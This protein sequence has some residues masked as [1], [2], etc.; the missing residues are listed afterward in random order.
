MKKILILILFFQLTSFSFAELKNNVIS[1][2]AC[3]LKVIHK[4]IEITYRHSN[5]S[6]NTMPVLFEITEF[7][8]SCFI[9]DNVYLWWT[10]SYKKKIEQP[11]VSVVYGNNVKNFKAKITGEAGPKCWVETGTI[12]YRADITD[13]IVG[14]GLYSI[15]VETSQ[16]ETDGLTLLII[17]R[18]LNSK[19]EGHLYIRDGLITKGDGTFFT[20]TTQVLDGFNA[21]D[22]ADSAWGLVIISDIQGAD[23]SYTMIVNGEIHKY[24]PKFW[25]SEIIPINIK[26]NQKSSLFGVSAYGDCYS[27]AVMG[28]YFQTSSCTNCFY[29]KNTYSNFKDTLVCQDSDV[30]LRGFG[31]DKYE[32]I[33]DSGKVIG[34]GR[35]FNYKARRDTKIL[36]R[37]FY[38]SCGIGEDSLTIRV[39]KKPEI[40]IQS[41]PQEVACLMT[42]K[43]YK[44]KIRNFGFQTEKI[45]GMSLKARN[46]FKVKNIINFPYYLA[47]NSDIDIEIEFKPTIIG[48]IRDTLVMMIEN[49]CQTEYLIPLSGEGLIN[50]SFVT[51]PDTAAIIGTRDFQIPLKGRLIC[52][53]YD[54]VYINFSGLISFDNSAYEP[55]VSKSKNVV[56]SYVSNGDR[57]LKISGRIFNIIDSMTTLAVLNGNVLFGRQHTTPLI[58][59]EFKWEDESISVDKDNGSL[60]VDACVFEL[61]QI[62]WL[63]NVDFNIIQKPTTNEI[64]IEIVNL[65]YNSNSSLSDFLNVY[66]YLGEIIIQKDLKSAKNSGKTSEIILDLDNHPSGL[67]FFVLKVEN[68]YISKK[69]LFVR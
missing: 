67:Y 63:K 52:E 42:P 39:I 1:R 45:L 12:G 26:K 64:K 53:I 35:T 38:N 7:P 5:Y 51:L 8:D 62:E 65:E 27:W 20:D 22:N 13:A 17:Y 58:I 69:F 44:V 47:S 32:W 11:N 23:P 61:G 3:G 25:N 46:D 56:Q 33:D 19:S 18:D 36:L 37:G 54:S 48:L 66:N 24:E 34:T 21:C 9:V 28:I 49:Q 41:N 14:N 43:N 57:K 60:T 40:S 10:V 50:N 4:S 30:L 2:S 15:A 31:A 68:S 59:E 29:D 16:Y 6:G 55:E